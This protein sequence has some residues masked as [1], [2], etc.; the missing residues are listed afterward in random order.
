MIV[1]FLLLGAFVALCFSAFFSGSETAFLS[2]SRERILHMAREG[3]VRAKRIQKALSDMSW[4]TTTLLIGNNI[5]NVSYS[6]AT[7]A[8]S[9]HLFS[10]NEIASVVWSCFAAFIVLY[11]SEFIPKLLCSARPLRRSLLLSGPFSVISILLSPITYIAIKVTNFFIPS[12]KTRDRLTVRDLVRI[13]E[14]R[15]DG[16]CLSD[17]ESALITKIIILRSKG[18]KITVES[19]LDALRD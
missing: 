10:Q 16:V 11:T 17:V 2:V 19:L 6:A 14:D 4:T 13:L 12:K 18:K 15:K 1:M 7:A 5:A 9:V 8:L 3:G